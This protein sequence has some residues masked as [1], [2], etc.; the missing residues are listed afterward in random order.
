M[1]RESK[2]LMSERIVLRRR[3]RFAQ[4]SRCNGCSIFSSTIRWTYPSLMWNKKSRFIEQI[5]HITWLT[6]K[7]PLRTLI[8]SA[9]VDWQKTWLRVCR[10]DSSGVVTHDFKSEVL[11]N[12]WRGF[13]MWYL[14]TSFDSS[15]YIN[16][17]RTKHFSKQFENNH[18]FRLLPAVECE[19]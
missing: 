16:K 4:S 6:S 17:K 9:A 2:S 7:V 13:S 5:V 11:Q 8:I 19:R 1:E 14:S 18:I 10:V 12:T 15:F 3:P